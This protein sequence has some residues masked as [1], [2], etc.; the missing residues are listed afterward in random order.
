ME[1]VLSQRKWQFPWRLSSVFPARGNCEAL[2]V[3]APEW[4]PSPLPFLP[5]VSLVR[6]QLSSHTLLYSTSGLG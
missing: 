6:R 2:V 5:A 1:P 4:L 3:I